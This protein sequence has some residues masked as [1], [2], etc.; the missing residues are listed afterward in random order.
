LLLDRE[1]TNQQMSSV[2]SPARSDVL[3]IDTSTIAP[4]K[5]GKEID[6]N[7]FQSSITSLLSSSS[8]TKHQV[9]NPAIV[10]ISAF[11][12]LSL[13]PKENGNVTN[14]SAGSLNVINN[15][16]YNND[17]DLFSSYA[18]SSV[19]SLGSPI[20]DGPLKLNQPLLVPMSPNSPLRSVKPLSPP[21][22]SQH[23][24]T[25]NSRLSPLRSATGNQTKG[26]TA[27]ISMHSILL[28]P[29]DSLLLPPSTLPGRI[30]SSASLRKKT[31]QQSF[32]SLTGENSS[33]SSAH[34]KD[35]LDNVPPTVLNH[36]L[37]VIQ[38]A[39]EN[40]EENGELEVLQSSPSASPATS[41]K[42][43][44]PR[45]PMF[46]PFRSKKLSANPVASMANKYASIQQ[47]HYS[48]NKSVL[49]V[50]STSGS[51]RYSQR[52]SIIAP[53][54]VMSVPLTSSATQQQPLS[55]SLPALTSL[56]SSTSLG[57]LSLTTDQYNHMNP[58]P[59]SNLPMGIKSPKRV[60]SQSDLMQL[61]GELEGIPSSPGGGILQPPQ[62][63]ESHITSNTS[64]SNSSS[65]GGNG[66][67]ITMTNSEIL[68]AYDFDL[69]PQGRGPAAEKLLSSS[70]TNLHHQY[71]QSTSGLPLYRPTSS[72]KFFRN[73]S[74]EPLPYQVHKRI[75]G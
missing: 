65:G 19:V 75:L 59:S 39:L 64:I 11:N 74:L 21:S 48:V 49:S 17:L 14:V 72:A 13:G 43:K 28:P 37:S 68:P 10:S 15:S 58:S 40:N 12:S 50:P 6:V 29:E 26:L 22:S 54:P 9:L 7:L 69:S 2:S 56:H 31:A 34:Q 36:N 38:M 71:H 42:S 63:Q 27:S 60:S 4:I 70:L 35:S 30:S 53:P 73:Q 3:S 61:G 41:P 62:R 51:P 55:S 5:P 32:P 47:Y 18:D 25:L 67:I 1:K 57:T 24:P 23:L 45:Q 66:G 16:E 33:T 46:R 20:A 8:V 44:L 52:P